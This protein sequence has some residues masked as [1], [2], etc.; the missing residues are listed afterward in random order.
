MKKRACSKFIVIGLLN[1]RTGG[2]MLES[3]EL[4]VLRGRQ[5]TVKYGV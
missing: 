4:A 2:T 3:S 5:R 1:V